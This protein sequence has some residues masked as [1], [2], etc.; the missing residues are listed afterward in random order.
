MDD[1]TAKEKATE[2]E[3]NDRAVRTESTAILMAMMGTER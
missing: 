1:R 2:R 3:K